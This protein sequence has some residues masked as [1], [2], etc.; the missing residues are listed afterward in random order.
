MNTFLVA[1]EYSRPVLTL[2]QTSPQ[3]AVVQ[4]VFRR[5]INLALDR[6]V[7]ALLSPELPRMP[8]GIRLAPDTLEQ[9]Y[10]NLRPGM[11]F[12]LGDGKLS[13]PALACSLHLPDTPAW[14][15]RPPIETR[16]WNW[17]TV[18]RHAH[19]LAHMLI[20][21]GQEEG[22]AP[23]A[24]PLPLGGEGKQTPLTQM[25]QPALRKLMQATW[26]W[27][28][29]GIEEATSRLA[30]LGPGLTPAGDD[31][32]G[33]FA[34]VMALLGRQLGSSLVGSS[35]VGS[36]PLRGPVAGWQTALSPTTG[37]LKGGDPTGGEEWQADK[38]WGDGRVYSRGDPLRSPGG[39]RSSR[40][41][42]WGEESAAIIAR[43]AGPRTTALS[44]TLLAHAARGEVAEHVGDLLLA[45]ALP[46]HEAQ[47]VRQRAE[48][49]LASG[50]TSGSDTLLGILLGLQ[51]LQG[52]LPS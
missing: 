16:Q 9:L 20:D 19:T 40:D 48:R 39:V 14:E 31:V 15:P 5:A 46:A 42:A 50:A 37:P 45:L 33:G 21:G 49:L 47:V 26:Q 11:A 7:L 41:G 10:Q 18:T 6:K 29:S 32:L 22:L 3:T 12:L 51:T 36:P 44:A 24:G 34:A 30:G 23:L 52:G 25:A 8:N 38:A 13:L 2:F 17:Q 4:S 27:D 1:L 43:V 35:P 28:R